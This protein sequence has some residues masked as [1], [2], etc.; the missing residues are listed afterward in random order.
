MTLLDSRL[1]A[2]SPLMTA[3][4]WMI[5]MACAFFADSIRGERSAGAT[6][7]LQ[8]STRMGSVEVEALVDTGNRLHEPISGLPVIIVGKRCMYGILDESCL[9][10]AAGRLPPGF[11]IVRY[12][13]LGG[14]GEMQCFR[15]ESVC[16]WQKGRWSDVSDVW[17]AI[18]PEEIPSG[19]EALAPAIF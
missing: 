12:G 13:V 1:K 17:I 4:G 11:R 3:A 7:L 14:S 19:V 6:V 2:G 9:E 8:I 18:C 5:V 16:I 10:Q 15:P